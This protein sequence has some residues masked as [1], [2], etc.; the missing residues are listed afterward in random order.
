MRPIAQYDYNPRID[1]SR[2]ETTRPRDF[3]VSEYMSNF[4]GG[5]A[6]G[7]VSGIV[8]HYLLGGNSL[9]GVYNNF[10]SFLHSNSQADAL[11]NGRIIGEKLRFSFGAGQSPPENA[12]NHVAS[13]SI[14]SNRVSPDVT[15][16]LAPL[17]SS[18][19][20]A[21]GQPSQNNV[22]LL[23]NDFLSYYSH[24]SAPFAI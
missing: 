12:I 17:D 18:H 15:Q 11:R 20:G 5:L 7:A 13:V 9:F 10:E 1:Y 19:Q 6:Q 3:D 21:S 24:A 14:S 2:F 22:D 23:R 16:I 8:G 4:G